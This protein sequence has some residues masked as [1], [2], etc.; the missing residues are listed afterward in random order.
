[1]RQPNPIIGKAFRDDTGL[2]RWVVGKSTRGYY[3]LLWLEEQ[4]GVWH[5]GGISKTVP[6]GIEVSAPQL[7]DIY[8]LAGTFDGY[9][10]QM[11]FPAEAQARATERE[12]LA[13]VWKNEHPIVAGIDV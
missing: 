3:Q 2:V 4:T 5:Q 6:Q 10:E 9:R 7:G 1:M 13:A 12:R 11:A 8:K